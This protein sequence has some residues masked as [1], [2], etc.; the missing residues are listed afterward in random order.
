MLWDC[1]LAW[2]CSVNDYYSNFSPLEPQLPSSN[3]NF[4]E[5]AHDVGKMVS[6]AIEF[7]EQVQQE[8]NS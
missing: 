7:K 3:Q 8:V 5:S 1:T 4:Q 2:T 6:T